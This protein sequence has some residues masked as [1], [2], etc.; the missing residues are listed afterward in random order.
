MA[1]SQGYIGESPTMAV[2]TAILGKPAVLINSRVSHLGNMVELQGKY[3]LLYN[4][5]RYEDAVPFLQQEFFSPDLRRRI[6]AARER[7]LQ[8]KMDISTW[9]ADIVVNFCQERHR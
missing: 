7:L 2:E 3:G 6:A 8:E 9:I 4:A 1:F 5:E